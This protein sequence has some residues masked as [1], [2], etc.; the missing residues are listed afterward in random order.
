[1]AKERKTMKGNIWWAPSYA[2]SSLRTHK[3]R[4]I[5][6]ALILA[7]S[8]SI[9]TTVFIWTATGTEL[10][11]EDY[12][13][14]NA[15][16][17]N[18]RV[19]S[20]LTD[21]S[22]LTEARDFALASDFAEYAHVVPSSICILQGDWPDW[23]QY[24]MHYLNYAAGI[25]DGRII[26]ANDEIVDAFSKEVEWRGN[27]SIDLGEVLVSEY[28]VQTAYDVHGIEIDVGSVIDID[29]LRF[30]AQQR[31]FDDEWGTTE[32]LGRMR[33]SGLKVAG[34][35]EVVAVS[36]IGQSFNSI[37]RQNWDPFS[38]S[39]D[40]VLGINDAVIMLQDQVNEQVIE[41]VSTRGYFS[42]VGFIR[43]SREGLIGAGATQVVANLQD[44]KVQ[45]EE[46]FPSLR[47]TG[48]ETIG[49]LESHIAIY[50]RSQVLILLGLPVMIMG[51]MLT[52]FTSETSISYRKGEISALRA[53]GASF[54][55]IFSAVIW[56]S[57]ALA[58]IGFGVGFLISLILAP[59]MGSSTGLLSF[60]IT[61][62]ELYWN[63]TV[64]PVQ[65][66]ALAAAIALYLPSSYLLHV[67]RRIDVSEVGQ[68]T[69]RNEY[70]APEET[71][72][73]F[74]WSGLGF[75]LTLLFIMPILIIPRGAFAL[76]EV[77]ASTLLLFAAS[78]L[79]SRAMRLA[80]AYVSGKSRPLFGEKSLYVKQSL[81]RRKGQFI[82]LMI[83]LTLT[84]SSTTMALIQ[85]QSLEQTM[86]QELEYALG[87]DIRLEANALPLDTVTSMLGYEGVVDATPVLQTAAV[88]ASNYFF[89][90]GIDPSSYLAVG[91]FSS[92]SFA[93][94]T[95]TEVLTVL[96]STPNGIV[97]SEYHAELWEK[98]LNDIVTVTFS[99]DASETDLDFRIVGIMKSAPG[100][101]MASTRE[102]EGIPFGSY[103]GFQVRSGGF[104]LVNLDFLSAQS[105]IMTADLFLLD[106]TDYET[107]APLVEQLELDKNNEVFT[108]ETIDI[109]GLRGL[110]A[111][112]TGMQGLT[113]ISYIM[114]AAMGLFAIVLFLG[115]AV[116]ERESEYA[117]FRAL[118]GTKKQVV[119]M[120]FGEFAGI[121]LA[122]ILISF[123]LGI[124]F[125]LV[126]TSLTMGIYH[127]F[128]ILPEVLA[129]PVTIMI[130]TIA[131]ETI[132][133]VI[134]CYMP[135]RRAG[136]TDPATTLR[137]L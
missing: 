125:G 99:T 39:N 68:P 69:Q 43:A 10:A 122:A 80:T 137:N 115:S 35:Y 83:V 108:I 86:A 52:V 105:D 8:I 75:V 53:K 47:I 12:F 97:I 45:L 78:Y 121:I 16:Q 28:F 107:V 131:L 118:G 32:D 87:A 14:N 25:K 30:G 17:I 33:I 63:N 41:E 93:S 124:L 64:I 119:S 90:E 133:M 96:E 79:G 81:R 84:L 5:G 55:Q 7:V 129:F 89:L 126:M 136:D 48:L 74:Y 26:L 70:E 4:N 36:M 91:K 67:S 13:N 104:S 46:R 23:Y 31:R 128:P 76:I 57:I 71:S 102:L 98:R 88:V 66:I 51:L 3:V 134:A 62:Y 123:V 29:L 40:P 24:N 114:C 100:F 95:P 82:P 27:F 56:E 113:M 94:G 1:M 111:F 117:V 130:L 92:D 58:V 50:V 103:F 22:S 21:Y 101:G 61:L 38:L 85:T 15:Y 20:A 109:M 65:A 77:L 72:P 135:A 9:P 54:N 42:P 6:I 127:V 37:Q 110:S 2:I 59:L 34:I 19:D 49:E 73:W 44:L 60:D 18:M 11:V 120:V 106:V 112:L 116:S 132:A